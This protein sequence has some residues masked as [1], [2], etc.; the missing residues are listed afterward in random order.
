M[1]CDADAGLAYCVMTFQYTAWL[2]KAVCTVFKILF[3]VRV[4]VCLYS[5]DKSRLCS[6]KEDHLGDLRKRAEYQGAF[7]QMRNGGGER[8]TRREPGTHRVLEDGSIILTAREVRV[9]LNH[10]HAPCSVNV[11][12][13]P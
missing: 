8:K 7:Q 11:A 12:L 9:E 13:D 2:T 10:R 5:S 6:R 3:R 4:N 1:I